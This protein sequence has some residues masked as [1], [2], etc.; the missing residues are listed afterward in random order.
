MAAKSKKTPSKRNK[1][2]VAVKSKA[3]ASRTG[4]TCLV[5][6]HP[7][8][9]ELDRALVNG[10]IKPAEVARRVGCSPSSVSRHVKNH[11][12]KAIQTSLQKPCANQSAT[13]E[14]A[15]NED[16]ADMDLIAEVKGLYANTKTILAQLE[17]EPNWKA[18]KAFY[19][20]ARKCLE[21]LGKF[22]GKIETGTTVNIMLSPVWVQIK[23]VMI[24]TLEPYP[25]AKQAVA[26]ALIK[27]D[28]GGTSH[29]I[30]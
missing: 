16:N 19:G 15:T 27:I 1:K 3:K 2:P 23:T 13:N 5:C 30:S 8:R 24:S 6:A 18:K 17:S 10:S 9:A 7:D 22:L 4:R 11:I 28:E 21:L 20:E 25:E 12:V 26:N 14:V 29:V